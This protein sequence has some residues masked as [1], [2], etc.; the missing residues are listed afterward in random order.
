MTSSSEDKKDVKQ[1][2]IDFKL[3]NPD[4]PIKDKTIVTTEG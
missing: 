1:S 2:K 3:D 4:E